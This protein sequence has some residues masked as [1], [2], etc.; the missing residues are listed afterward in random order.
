M[1]EINYINTIY[2]NNLHYYL[3]NFFEVLT[4]H[5]RANLCIADDERLGI[6]V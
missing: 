5:Y 1:L 2:K 4:S 3:F 6:Y